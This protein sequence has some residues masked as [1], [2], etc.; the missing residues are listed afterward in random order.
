[1]H[2]HNNSQLYSSTVKTAARWVFINFLQHYFFCLVCW[3]L[4][5]K[6]KKKAINKTIIRIHTTIIIMFKFDIVVKL[7]TPNSVHNNYII[8]TSLGHSI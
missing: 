6:K 1:M 3:F 5:K 7:T 8:S 2:M 4:E